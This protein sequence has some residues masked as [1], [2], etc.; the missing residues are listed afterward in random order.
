MSEQNKAT[1][2]RF[3]DE[4]I[5]KKNLAVIDELMA[6]D[7]IEHEEVPPGI[8]SGT[9]GLK[10]MIGMF[11]SGFPDLQSTTD[12]VIAEGD[13]VLLA[14]S[15]SGTLLLRRDQGEMAVL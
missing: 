3:V 12:L 5:N 2:R 4:V 10:Q 11:F 9:E 14:T 6:P 15:K 8:P 13:I 1:Y 7:Y